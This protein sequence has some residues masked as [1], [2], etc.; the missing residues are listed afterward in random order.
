M[1][2]G[3]A[4]QT[5]GLTSRADITRAATGEVV[6]AATSDIQE[7]AIGP[8][9]IG[10][11][12]STARMTMGADGAVT[13]FRDVHIDGVRIG[14]LAVTISSAGLDVGGVPVP[15][16][17]GSTLATLLKSAGITFE[18]LPA[19]DFPDRV[20]APAVRIMMPVSGAIVGASKGTFAITVGS[21]T[22]YLASVRAGGIPTM[23]VAQTPPLGLPTNTSP[24]DTSAFA[25]APPTSPASAT[26]GLASVPSG[27]GTPRPA[28]SIGG[29]TVP[30]ALWDIKVLY[31]LVAACAVG[32]WA[33]GHL[34][35][36]L[37]VRRP[38][39]SSVG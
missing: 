20:I 23:D 1:S 34:F 28:A 39:K 21:A 12:V 33:M 38:W 2:L 14:G 7:L 9:T 3:G 8:L 31:M 17:V 25:S 35:R 27:L 30:I 26:P 10:H 13:R 37:G 4:G 32:A 6:A 36:L 29:V 11:V 19:Q 16:P 22:A 24:T 5:S 15:A 18:L